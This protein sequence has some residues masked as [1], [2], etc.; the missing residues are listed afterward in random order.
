MGW[1]GRGRLAGQGAPLGVR[2]V[3][4]LVQF[5]AVV[6]LF[7]VACHGR[8]VTGMCNETQHGACVLCRIVEAGACGLM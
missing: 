7:P 8:H 3:L 4:R 5:H 6:H 1:G 2:V